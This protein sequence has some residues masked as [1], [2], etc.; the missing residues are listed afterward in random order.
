MN[1]FDGKSV[2]LVYNQA[3]A[4]HQQL[5][6]AWITTMAAADLTVINTNG[7]D[8][9]VGVDLINAQVALQ[10]DGTFDYVM[11]AALPDDTGAGGLGRPNYDTIALLWQKLKPTA[12]GT[13]IQD[14]TAQVGAAVNTIWLQA[15]EATND[16][17]NDLI[18]VIDGAVTT[19]A[20][21]KAII[22][23]TAVNFVAEVG[24]ANMAGAPDGDGYEVYADHNMFIMQAPSLGV[25]AAY[26]YWVKSVRA[27]DAL[28]VWDY[29][30]SIDDGYKTG[31][32]VNTPPLLIHNI[33]QW[34]ISRT[35]VTAV[36]AATPAATAGGN[37]TLTDAGEF[38][39]LDLA[40][41]YVYIVAGAGAGQ[42]AQIVSNTANVL[43]VQNIGML[44]RT[45]L[46]DVWYTN[47]AAGSVFRVVDNKARCFADIFSQ[48]YIKAMLN[49]LADGGQG[50]LAQQLLDRDLSMRDS[51]MFGKG[52]APR[53]NFEKLGNFLDVFYGKKADL[54]QK[55]KMNVYEV[56][57]GIFLQILNAVAIT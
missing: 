20:Y 40:G 51:A 26:N 44:G 57:A 30:H 32:V 10:T 48:F 28:L 39:G 1:K 4:E 5:A 21:T 53:Q 54:N 7:L 38:V 23:Y 47:P 25:A 11:V 37:D 22:D 29:I 56:G 8:D 2:L 50:Y 52:E 24:G 3:V 33:G 19:N 9:T 31:G 6:A 14:G 13:V 16:Y 43:T 15:A 41:K 18:V 12:R 34:Q 27:G 46:Q 45:G 49:T 17:Y 42:F 36:A 55:D 35:T